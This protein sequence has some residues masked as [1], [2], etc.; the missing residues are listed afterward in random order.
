MNP[1]ECRSTRAQSGRSCAGAVSGVP[2]LRRTARKAG[3]TNESLYLNFEINTNAAIHA[4]YASGRLGTESL[5]RIVCTGKQMQ[6]GD[7]KGL[8]GALIFGSGLRYLEGS[9]REKKTEDW[10]AADGN[11]AYVL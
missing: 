5:Y 9:D 1:A 8:D 3:L 10:L 6:C 11:S 2:G 4:Q 7:R